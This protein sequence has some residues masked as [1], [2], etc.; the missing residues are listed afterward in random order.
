M[1]VEVR[2]KFQGRKK[3]KQKEKIKKKRYS[4]SSFLTYSHLSYFFLCACARKRIERIIFRSPE[5]VTLLTEYT[6]GK[7]LCGSTYCV[8]VRVYVC[9]CVCVNIVCAYGEDKR[10]RKVVLRY[11]QLDFYSRT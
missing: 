1:V 6:D 10:E 11:Y 4:H 9:V 8:C 2:K 3:C 7:M 5:Y